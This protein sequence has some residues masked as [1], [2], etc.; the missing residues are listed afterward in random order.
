MNVE[1]YIY[2]NERLLAGVVESFEYLRWTRRYARS[3]AF[4]MK[5]IATPESLSLLQTGN[6]LWK[7]DDE[8]IGVIE[9]VELIQ[10]DRETVAVSGRFATSLLSR[11]IVWGT[12]TL[13][14]DLSACVA[15]LM[16]HHL[17][18]PADSLRQITGIAFSSP[19]MGIAVNTQVSYKNLMDT[20]TGLCEAS[21][22]GIKTVFSPES[23]LLTVALYTGVVSQAVF[24]HEY[25]NL[26]EQSYTHS[27]MGYANTALIGGESEG[28]SRVMAAITGDTGEARREVFVDAKD[29]RQEDFGTGYQDALLYR[30]QSKLSTLSMLSAFDAEVNPHGNLRYKTDFD[31]G[32]VVTVLSRKWGVTLTTR[33]TEVTE[34]YDEG[35]LSLGLVFGKGALTLIDKLKGG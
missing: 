16:N 7:S 27:D 18:T 8:E 10:A 29:L 3:G 28:G 14:N 21:D 35:G 32:Q 19:P 33:I 11:R 4:E 20:I 26:T 9:Q 23:G 5:A 22:R 25:E 12:E 15:Q 13:S 31:L 1:I 6:Y 34:T 24:S 30:G 17:I 2:N